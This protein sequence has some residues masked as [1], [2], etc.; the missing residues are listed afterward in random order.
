VCGRLDRAFGAARAVNGVGER[1]DQRADG[2]LRGR[3]A[4]VCVEERGGGGRVVRA[5]GGAGGGVAGGGGGG[6]VWFVE[7]PEGQS[8][9]QGDYF[10]AGRVLGWLWVG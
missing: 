4:E 6:S 7:G 3:L 2:G 5:G 1:G 8:G 10:D 9:R